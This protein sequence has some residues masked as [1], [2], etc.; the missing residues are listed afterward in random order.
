[1]QSIAFLSAAGL[2]IILKIPSIRALTSTVNP[3]SNNKLFANSRSEV[4]NLLNHPLQIQLATGE[5]PL[6]SFRRLVNDRAIIL[7]GLQA[8]TPL[9]FFDDLVQRKAVDANEWLAA[10][11]AAGKTISVPDVAC[12]NCGGNHLNIDCPDD[13]QEASPSANALRSVLKTS[14]LA[15]ASAVLRAYG[16]S[17]SRLLEAASGCGSDNNGSRC[18]HGWLEAHAVQWS[19]L[20]SACED[21][22]D[23]DDNDASSSYAICLSMFYNW[24]DGEAATTGIRSTS[25]PMSASIVDAI[26]ALEPG[27]AKQRDKHQSFVADITGVASKQVKKDAATAKVNAAAAYLAAKKKKIL[28]NK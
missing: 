6:G 9:G 11:E 24:I 22:L 27:Y 26:E 17:C 7:D 4:L 14:G 5:L 21:Q 19:N 1:M 15:G 16:F 2:F 25:D 23:E 8:A 28:E 20:A 10:A 12:Y 3:N 18:Y 13:E